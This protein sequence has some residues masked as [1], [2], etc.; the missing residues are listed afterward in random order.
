MT[1]QNGP[2]AGLPAEGNDAVPGEPG[3]GSA[4][5]TAGPAAEIP[6]PTGGPADEADRSAGSSVATAAWSDTLGLTASRCAQLLLVAAVFVGMVWLLLRVSVVVIAALVAL[7]LASAVYPLVNWLRRKGWSSLL[8]TGAAF[9]GILAALGG[10]VTG[11]VFAI[12]GEWAELS[13][14]AVE[15]W[16]ELQGFITASPLP[17]DTAAVDT[18]LQQATGFITSST[19][20]DSALTGITAA[21][22]FITG[23]VLMIVILFFFLKDGPK[24]WN[25]TLRWFRGDT[26]A[27]LAESGDRAIQILGGYVRGTAIIAFVD[28]V[29]IGIPL[30]VLGVP[31]ALPLAIIVF[32]GGFLPIVGATIAGTLA[33]LVALVTNGPVV[34]LIV[35]AV[36]VAVNQLEGDLLQPVVMGRTL[37]LHAIVVL[38]ALAVG[39][40]VGGI[41]GAILAVPLTAVG[42]AVAQVWTDTYQVGDDPVLGEDPLNPKDRVESKASMAERWKY[43]QMRY[44]RRLNRTRHPS[45]GAP[46]GEEDRVERRKKGSHRQK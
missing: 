12:R 10:V 25:F 17:I 30:A 7:I 24:M 23:L 22:E 14:S 6:G 3:P 32:I 26:R 39:T 37:S 46:A 34:A 40:I 13:E 15:G 4:D 44:Q 18:A 16:D 8:A 45:P 2:L 11:I 31:L 21:T 38:L 41:F 1:T 19:F 43:Q 28:A 29:F 27:S 42:W 35:V 33:A 9:I 5:P 36:V 20:V